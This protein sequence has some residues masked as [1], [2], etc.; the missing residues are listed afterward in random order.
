MEILEVKIKKLCPEA[1]IPTY[2]TEGA[3]GMDVTAVNFGGTEKY[4]EYGTGLSFEI[5]KGYVL[6][7]FPRSS[8]SKMDLMLKNCVGII[9]SDYRGELKLRFQRFGSDKYKVGKNVDR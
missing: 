5:P 1:I 3:A 6:L 2:S 4:M 9:D 7:A 8:I